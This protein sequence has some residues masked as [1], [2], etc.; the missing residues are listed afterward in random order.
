M[1]SRKVTVNGV[2]CDSQYEGEVLKNHPDL[3]RE[4][5]S[6]PYQKEY[7]PDFMLLTRSGKAIL[8]ECKGHFKPVDRTKMIAVKKAH[9]DKDIRIMFMNPN[10]RISRKGKMTYA[11]WCNKHGFKCCGGTVIPREWLEE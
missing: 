6:L 1:P 8:I 11:G 4:P 5:L 7:I 10:Q 3:L 9:P 2:R